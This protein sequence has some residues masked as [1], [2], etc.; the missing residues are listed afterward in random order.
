MSNDELKEI[1]VKNFLIGTKRLCITFNKVD[2]FI[3]V[4]DGTKYLALFG[5]EKYGD[6]YNKIRY[7]INQKSCI[8]HVISHN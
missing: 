6:I 1:D 5:P 3:T 8:T 7:L 2:E 4:Y